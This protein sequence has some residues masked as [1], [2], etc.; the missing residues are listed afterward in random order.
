MFNSA[1]NIK[2]SENPYLLF[3]PFLLLYVVFVL[4]I[5]TDPLWGDEV[6]YIR[7]AQNLVHGFYSPPPPDIDLHNS[8]GYPIVLTPFV[9]LNSPYLFMKLMNPVF[10]YLSIILLFKA[11]KQ[12][13]T[14]RIALLFSL[15]WACYYNSFDFMPRMY[16]E[17]FTSFLVTLLILLLTKAFRH[18][19]SLS[20]NKYIYFAGFI[21][22]YIALTKTIFGY[23]LLF[24]LIGSGLLWL[25]N[26][27]ATNYRK[28]LLILL[29]ASAT[30]MPYLI[31][32]YQLTGRVFYL[33]STG[34]NN[35]YWMT[36]PN[37]GEYGDWSPEPRLE[38]DSTPCMVSN[39]GSL[40][41]GKFDLKNRKNDIPGTLDSVKIHHQNDFEEIN[42]Y[43]G[44]ARDDAY[45]RIAISNMKSHPVKFIQNCISNIGRI[46]FN[47]PY[48]YTLQKPGTLTRLPLNMII[49]VMTLFCLIPTFLNWR[50]INFP[51]RF[52]L[53]F[54]LLYLGGSILGSAE[55]RMFSI[56][57]PILLF[58]IAYVLNKS[59]K[60]NLKFDEPGTQ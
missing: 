13:V 21:I 57:A 27:K 1:K 17:L 39:P 32:T 38:A 30:I 33:G 20:G 26:R 60:L 2:L 8:P 59:I 46:L 50:K 56:T 10:H 18:S 16:C 29:V 45:R 52:M 15:F 49:L 44:L 3:S 28:S 47:Y 54:T 31:Y 4:I 43:T 42:K 25:L 55:I 37:Y 34:G 14:V 51:I 9:A 36:T 19:K 24:M 48:S 5:H 22:G 40:R 6:D 7:L 12:I 53:I 23:V 35:L 41:A 58:W 11:L